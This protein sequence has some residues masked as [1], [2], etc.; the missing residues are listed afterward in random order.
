[1]TAIIFRFQN[2]H[3]NTEENIVVT[4]QYSRKKVFWCSLFT[5]SVDGCLCGFKAKA[6]QISFEF[7]S[8]EQVTR[9]CYRYSFM[10]DMLAFFP[11]HL[12]IFQCV[13]FVLCKSI[14][15]W[16]E[17]TQ[18]TRRRHLWH[19]V[20]LRRQMDPGKKRKMNF[21]SKKTEH[22]RLIKQHNECP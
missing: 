12:N 17:V 8:D 1:M 10:W 16:K 14:T 6:P 19:L 3:S 18:L 13:I 2:T 9:Y 20:T 5:T 15:G 21:F 7:Q 4:V 11:L 22:L